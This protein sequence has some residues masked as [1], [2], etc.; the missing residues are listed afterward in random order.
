MG[1]I[2]RN[3]CTYFPFPESALGIEASDFSCDVVLRSA[4]DKLGPKAVAE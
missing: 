3:C 1:H 2:I 4:I